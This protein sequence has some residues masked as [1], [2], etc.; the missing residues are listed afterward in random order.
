MTVEELKAKVEKNREWLK[1]QSGHMVKFAE[2]GPV[3]IGL[4]DA[5]VETLETMQARMQG[6]EKAVK[7]INERGIFS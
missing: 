7:D 2:T 6:L 3:G 1:E 5:I 4:I